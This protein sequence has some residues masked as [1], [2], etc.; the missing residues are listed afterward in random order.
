MY[1]QWNYP[2]VGVTG[3]HWWY[4]NSYGL[5]P[6]GIKPLADPMLTKICDIMTPYATD[7]QQWVN[8]SWL[9]CVSHTIHFHIIKVSNII[10]LSSQGNAP[11]TCFKHYHEI[12]CAQFWIFIFH[13][14]TS[15]CWQAIITLYEYMH[16][17]MAIGYWNTHNGIPAF[18]M[19]LPW[20]CI[21]KG[22]SQSSSFQHRP[23][24][25][26]IAQRKEMVN[27]GN[28]SELLH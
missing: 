22:V 5:V 11:A 21:V 1:L 17:T 10:V 15:T 24:Q 9:L 28:K 6:D 13:S 27:A 18:R 19:K 14:L 25:Q 16:Q 23:K 4:F 3:P 2:Q 12:H 8:N 7:R 20:L 26:D